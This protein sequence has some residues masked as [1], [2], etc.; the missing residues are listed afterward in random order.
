[1][2]CARSFGVHA[3]AGT[4]LSRSFQRPAPLFASSLLIDAHAVQ[5]GSSVIT[6]TGPLSFALA[7]LAAAS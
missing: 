6:A 3:E 7:T 4:D 2:N 5:L 1:M